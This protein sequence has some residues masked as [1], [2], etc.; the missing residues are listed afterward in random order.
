MSR[1]GRKPISIPKGVNVTL[2]GHTIR[3]KGPKGEMSFDL[4]PNINVELT[5]EQ[6][7]V[8]RNGEDK[9]TKAFHGLVRA[10]LSNIVVGVTQGFEKD[11]EIVGV[12]YRAQM[13]GQKLVLNLG[14]SNPVEYVPPKGITITTDGPTKIKVSGIDKQEVGQVAAIIRSFR[15]PEPYKGKGIRYVGEVV[16]RKTG[17]ASAK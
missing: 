15:A 3:V 7:K 5:D 12:G 6:I 1:I 13:Q 4:L 8:T 10:M 17:K 9:K 11:L 14:Y 2:S 16:K